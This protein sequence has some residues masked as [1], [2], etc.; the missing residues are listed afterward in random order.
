MVSHKSAGAAGSLRGVRQSVEDS[1]QRC[2]VLARS[3]EAAYETTA[4]DRITR[5]QPNSGRASCVAVW[6]AARQ[7]V[8]PGSEH[9]EINQ[10]QVCM[11]S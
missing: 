4:I 11:V 8:A 9:S 5:S 7:H 10:A 3:F 2:N 1:R 6:Q